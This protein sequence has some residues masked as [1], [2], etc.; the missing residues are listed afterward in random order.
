DFFG[1]E[2][3]AVPAAMLEKIPVLWQARGSAGWADVGV[4]LFTLALIVVL[5]R[6]APRLPGLIVAI[7]AGSLL[8]AIFGLPVETRCS[9][10]GERLHT[11]PG[12]AL[13][14]A[15]TR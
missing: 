9:R 14:S 6:A 1:L 10:V 12:P 2:T 4:G 3:G 5:R 8:V 11:L 7:A 15:I 13:P